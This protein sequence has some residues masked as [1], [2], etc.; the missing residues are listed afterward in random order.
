M[1][2]IIAKL[3]A[4]TG[5]DLE[6]DAEIHCAINPSAP[7]VIDKWGCVNETDAT[8]QYFV[9]Q[10]AVPK[11]TESLDAALG[12]VGD[13]S[14]CIWHDAKAGKYAAIVGE[15]DLLKMEEAATAELALVKAALKAIA[16]EEG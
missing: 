2:D 11:Y 12:L 8:G 9:K 6:V 10:I 5:P 1:K 7:W 14:Y 13:R 15:L 16:A 3:E 4:L